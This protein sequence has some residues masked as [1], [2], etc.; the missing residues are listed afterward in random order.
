MRPTTLFEPDLDALRT[1]APAIVV[2]IG[3]T[4]AGMLCDHTSRAL[5]GA[6]GLAPASFPGGHVGF[7]EDPPAFVTRLREVLAQLPA[8]AH[9]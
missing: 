7:V 3:D 1:G 2:G 4:S 9:Q 6:L 5:A 8:Q